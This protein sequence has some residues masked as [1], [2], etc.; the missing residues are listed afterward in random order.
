M[1][2]LTACHALAASRRAQCRI[3]HH[4]AQLVNLAF[5][6]GDQTQMEQAASVAR[7]N[8]AAA[9]LLSVAEGFVLAYS[10]RLRDA[11]KKWQLAADLARKGGAQER[12]ATLE[13]TEAM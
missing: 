5:V 3:S 7:K 4:S 8:P 9:D 11:R 6:K 12:E 1:V 2:I 13:A 10:G